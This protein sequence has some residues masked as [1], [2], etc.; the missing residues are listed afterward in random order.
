MFPGILTSYR[1]WD[2][3]LIPNFQF[4]PVDGPAVFTSTAKHVGL[5][6]WKEGG[7]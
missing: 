1:S 6:L 4:T 5:V 2:A 3:C 7:G